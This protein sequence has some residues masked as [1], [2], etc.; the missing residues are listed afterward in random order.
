MTEKPEPESHVMDLENENG[1]VDKFC[2]PETI[3]VPET[4]NDLI[5][6]LHEV[7]AEDK[8]NIEY[9]HTLMGSYKSNRKEW[10]QFAKFDPH[11]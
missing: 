4:L 5:G 3:K 2:D 8:V 7:F 1:H 9:V 6:Q 11:R 10:K